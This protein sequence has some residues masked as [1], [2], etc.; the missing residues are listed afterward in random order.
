MIALCAVLSGGQTALDMGVFT[1][2][3]QQ[4]CAIFKK[5]RNGVPQPRY[6]RFAECF[7]ASTRTDSVPVFRNSWPGSAGP[8][9]Q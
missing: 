2:A 4:F 5:L 9:R 1:E 7:A 8:T 3:K 6:L